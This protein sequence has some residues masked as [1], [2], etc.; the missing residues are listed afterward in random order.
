MSDAVKPHYPDPQGADMCPIEIE[1]M[2]RIQFL[3]HWIELFNPGVEE[4][5]YNARAM[6][7]F[8]GIDLCK[9]PVPDENIHTS[10]SPPDGAE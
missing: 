8:V 10:V 1:R 5:L 7:Q 4:A 2:L 9:E 6:R 3:Q